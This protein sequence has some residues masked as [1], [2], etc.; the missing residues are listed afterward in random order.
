YRLPLIP[1]A[2]EVMEAAREA[3]AIGAVLSGA[4][5]T[6]LALCDGEAAEVGE[7][8]LAAWRRCGVVAEARLLVPALDGARVV[9]SSS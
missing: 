6:I 9:D 8:M 3:G 2:G 7:A 5:P 1:G 4:G